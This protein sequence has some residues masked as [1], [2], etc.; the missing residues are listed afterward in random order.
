MYTAIDLFAGAGG[1]SYG[2]EQTGE[3]KIILA[4]E[5]NDSAVATYRTNHPDTVIQNDVRIIN[6]V[7]VRREY[8]PIDLVIGGPP[9]QGFSNA[10]RQKAIISANNG[11]VKEFIRAVR[12]LKPAMFVM[13]N[14]SMLKSETHR[15]YCVPNEMKE[16]K[17]LRIP[18]RED[19]ITLSAL[20]PEL[21]DSLDD[22]RKSLPDYQTY[23]WEEKSYQLINTLYKRLSSDSR[24][25][26][27]WE[28]S[29]C[30]LKKNLTND[31]R[32]FPSNKIGIAYR[33]LYDA[34]TQTPREAEDLSCLKKNIRIA[35]QY[36]RLF[37]QYRDIVSNHIA[38]EEIE[39]G[40]EIAVKVK[41]Y[42]V[43][44]YIKYS[45]EREKFPYNI[46]Y[47]VLNAADYGAPQKR[48]RFII[49][50]SRIGE[51]PMMPEPTFH[52]GNYR[53]VRE[54]IEDLEALIPSTDPHA[55]SFPAPVFDTTDNPLMESLRNAVR[56][57]NHFIT[58]TREIAQ[59]RFNALKEGG[60]FHTL[61]E[62]LKSTYS[63]GKRTQSSIYLKLKYD[64][65]SGTVLN[66]RKSM[67]V[68]P[69]IS[70]AMS[71]REAARLQTFPDSYVFRGNKDAQYQQVGNAV[72]PVLANAIAN[73][74]IQYMNTHYKRPLR[75]SIII[76]MLAD[77]E[78]TSAE[79][80]DRLGAS[81][82]TVSKYIRSLTKMK[83]IDKVKH[84]NRRYVWRVR[85]KKI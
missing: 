56:I 54:A 68:H 65:P 64:E 13:E 71:V 77:P 2:F 85:R 42:S 16:L 23:I 9:C 20:S 17:R 30:K 70:R 14:V 7:D 48:E 79:I 63:D 66:V 69:A 21:A 22:L 36:Q 6:Y 83:V 28:K 74:V 26:I 80:A 82:G 41:S 34:I 39:W 43:L 81:Q 25:R 57:E 37:R 72:P 84:G 3:F 32:S 1:L 50:G 31:L 51:K 44:D 76:E 47:K 78:S 27:T 59:E 52:E 33:M 55:D 73:V 15:F 45:L 38:I 4:A 11:L 5:N 24:F 58:A 12:D 62:N 19:R 67:W 53:T 35:I 18:I 60:N 40:K 49:I 75:E 61:P 46:S 10:N 8:G 29:A